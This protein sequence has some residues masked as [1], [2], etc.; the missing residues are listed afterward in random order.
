MPLPKDGGQWPPADVKPYI[1]QATAAAAWWSGDRTQLMQTAG[2]AGDTGRRRF[3]Q[4][5]N[6]GDTSKATALLHAPLAADI[7]AVS[8]D[9]LFGDE[10]AIT[11]D[12]ET[13]QAR[14]DEL[15]ENVGLDNIFVEGAETASATGGTYLRAAWDADLAQHGLSQSFPQTHA[16]PDFKYGRLV[17]CTLWEDVLV[18]G[19]DVWRHLERHD[20]G[21]VEHGLYVG[22]KTDLGKSVDLKQHPATANLTPTLTLPERLAGRLLVSYVPNVRPNRRYPWKPIGR[23]DWDG[24]DD[25]L[26]AIDEAWTSL[27]RDIRLGKAHIVVPEEWLKATGTRPGEVKQLDMDTEAFTSMNI[28]DS[29]EQKMEMYQP[30]IR[31]TEHIDAILALT[32][33]VVS[34][35]GY[36]PQTFGLQIEGRADSGTAL[37][38]REG[39]TDKTV[40]K[41]QRYWTPGIREHVETLLDIGEVVFNQPARPDDP[42]KG[43]K[44]EFPELEQDPVDKATWINTLRGARAM[45]IE[46]AVRKAQPDLDDQGVEDEVARIQEEESVA[47]PVGFGDTTDPRVTE[48]DQPSDQP[49]PTQE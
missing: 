30:D 34:A 23:P 1:D 8:A 37:R 49:D 32:E 44:V 16:V 20:R 11:V 31:V 38:V 39:K 43:V 28:A 12:D 2:S 21:T 42:T 33:R 35:A 41:K 15:R 48:T 10:V 18:D 40:A 9:L 27:M 19:N 4:R 46:T 6:T 17:G 14:V 29:T 3:W 22:S 7:A 45:S 24:A 25:F 13:T 26:D 47:D 5:R 36:S